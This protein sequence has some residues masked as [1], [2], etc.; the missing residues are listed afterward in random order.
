MK[1]LNGTFVIRSDDIRNRAMSS[2]GDLPIAEQPWEVTIK[3]HKS[4]R[5][6]EQNALMWSLLGELS[7]QVEWYGHRLTPE[8]WKDVMTASLHK[9]RAVPGLDG[10]F[11]I[12]GR[13]TSQMKVGEMT[14]L[15]DL[16]LAFGHQKDVKFRE[17]ETV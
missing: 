13:S 11:V 6:L 17:P 7:D 9:Q 2:V 5:S 3:E 16:I 14:D 10:G 15:I 1:R 8:E 12:L 4:K